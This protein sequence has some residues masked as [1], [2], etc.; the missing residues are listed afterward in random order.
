MP[1]QLA[2]TEFLKPW[3]MLSTGQPH[4]M[5]CA[6]RHCRTLSCG[7]PPPTNPAG[8]IACCEW[9]PHQCR[10]WWCSKE[11]TTGSS[12]WPSAGPRT[13][14]EAL[15]L[16]VS[17]HDRAQSGQG[18]SCCP[19]RGLAASGCS[20]GPGC[21]LCWTAATW[22]CRNGQNENEK[23]GDCSEIIG[24]HEGHGWSATWGTQLRLIPEQWLSPSGKGPSHPAAQ[25][26]SHHFS[27]TVKFWRCQF[28]QRELLSA[29]RQARWDDLPSQLRAKI[30]ISHLWSMFFNISEDTL[31]A[32]AAAGPGRT[33]E[34]PAERRITAPLWVT[35]EA[36]HLVKH[37]GWMFPVGH[38]AFAWEVSSN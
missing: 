22:K 38:E 9:A 21:G 1:L 19:E 11:G 16:H 23:W 30:W 20:S 27:D 18:D 5:L 12:S 7:P 36:L 10:C 15:G 4:W 17:K 3:R 33:E 37:G 31:L 24:S 8:W 28:P 35:S 32:A 14:R 29:K 34:E 26:L 25:Y 13:W 2:A 6:A